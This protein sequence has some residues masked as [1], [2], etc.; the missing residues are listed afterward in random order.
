[1]NDPLA[2]IEDEFPQRDWTPRRKWSAV[3][4]FASAIA[5]LAALFVWG[6]SHGTRSG[7]VWNFDELPLRADATQETAQ[8]IRDLPFNSPIEWRYMPLRH[9]WTFTGQV[10]RDLMQDFISSRLE[11]TSIARSAAGLS[12]TIEEPGSLTVGTVDAASSTIRLVTWTRAG[13]AVEDDPRF[14]AS[15]AADAARIDSL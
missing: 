5:M 10:D 3:G 11:A 12:F 15:A 4:M 8:L 14:A 2:A 9:Q 13:G 7:R 6:T 1:M